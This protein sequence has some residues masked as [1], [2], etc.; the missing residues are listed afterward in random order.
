MK[1][2]DDPIRVILVMEVGEMGG[3]GYQIKAGW[4]VNGLQFLSFTKIS[5]HNVHIVSTY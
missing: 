2:N 4:R 1:I 5:I 3:K